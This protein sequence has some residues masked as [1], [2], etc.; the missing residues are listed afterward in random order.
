MYRSCA[1]SL[2]LL[3]LVIVWCEVTFSIQQVQL[4]LFA[5]LVY[6]WH[7]VSNYIAVEVSRSVESVHGVV[8]SVL[9]LLAGTLPKGTVP[10]GLLMCPLWSGLKQNVLLPFD[11]F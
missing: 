6:A 3:S 7:N 2:A 10:V 9:A 11:Y 5:F 4:S 1:V 8:V